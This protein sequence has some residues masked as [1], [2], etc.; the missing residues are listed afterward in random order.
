MLDAQNTNAVATYYGDELSSND[1]YE[2]PGREVIHENVPVRHEPQGTSFVS[3][4]TGERTRRA[5]RLLAPLGLAEDIEEGQV[6]GVEKP[7]IEGEQKWRV[8][9]VMVRTIGGHEGYVQHELADYGD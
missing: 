7:A 5:E 4:E 2:D 8:D 6:V 1:P 9:N 3:E